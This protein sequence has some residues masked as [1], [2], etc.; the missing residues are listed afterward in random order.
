MLYGKETIY[1]LGT[2]KVGKSDPISAM[3]DIFFVGLI[4]DRNTHKIV[5]ST[6]N[7]V[8]DITNDFIKSI[9]VSYDIVNESDQII[10]EVKE[11]FHGMA[12]KSVCAAI[13]DARN[14]YLNLLE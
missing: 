6:C 10:A 14:K 4:I 2:A 12:Q 13:K 1:I 3:Y 11:R 8:R 7:M 9:V 5:D